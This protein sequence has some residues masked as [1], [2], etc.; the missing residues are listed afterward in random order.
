MLYI[1]SSLS[2]FPLYS[3]RSRRYSRARGNGKLEIPPA[4]KRHILSSAHRMVPPILMYFI[5]FNYLS[6]SRIYTSAN[7]RL[8][9]FISSV[10]SMLWRQKYHVRFSVTIC[11]HAFIAIYEL[12]KSSEFVYYQIT[13]LSE[14]KYRLA[15]PFAEHNFGPFRRNFVIGLFQSLS[16]TQ[17][18]VSFTRLYLQICT[19]ITVSHLQSTNVG[20]IFVV[21]SSRRSDFRFQIKI[22]V[23]NA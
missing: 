2:L 21:H 23:F 7:I 4:Q 12:W 19:F 20:L 17:L 10:H 6:N 18:R 22:K 15:K 13:Q 1:W 16:K 3:L 9:R 5:Y 14:Q 11:P 8:W